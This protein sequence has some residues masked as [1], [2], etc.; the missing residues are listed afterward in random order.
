MPLVGRTKYQRSCVMRPLVDVGL[1]GMCR[2]LTPTNRTHTTPAV[3]G[4]RDPCCFEVTASKSAF[5]PTT[6][7]LND[8]G[9]RSFVPQDDKNRLSFRAPAR[10]V[11]G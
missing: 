4:V 1:Q 6:K 9:V 2:G 5:R 3:G 11:A 8:R 10:S 7:N